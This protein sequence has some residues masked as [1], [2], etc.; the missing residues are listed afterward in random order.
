M[1]ALGAVIASSASASLPELGGCEP[2]PVGHGKYKDAAC[3]EKATGAAKKTEGAYEW[4][5]GANFGWVFDLE[6]GFRGGNPHE[7]FEIRIGATTFET[8]PGGH[9]IECSNGHGETG[10]NLLKSTKEV[11]DTLL[12]WEGCYEV[13]GEEAECSSLGFIGGAEINDYA[14]YE[15][16]KGFRGTLGFL[17]GKGGEDPK[18]GF[19]LTS[20]DKAEILTTVACQGP[21]GTVWIGG[22]KKG[23]NAVISAI[24]PVDTMSRDYTQT[25]AASKPG[26]QQWTSFEGKQPAVL[27]EFV[28]HNFEQSAWTSTF[29]LEGEGRPIEIKARP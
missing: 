6:H 19:S 28:L 17:E 2:A 8:T 22:E 13:G 24:E 23:G 12:A 16:E 3:L 14:Q 25:F 15:E 1:L 5:T 29:E 18:V 27:D 11:S 9:K 21:L 7:N 26:V 20:F 4:Y 10:I